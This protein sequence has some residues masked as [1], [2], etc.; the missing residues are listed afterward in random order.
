[1][2]KLYSKPHIFKRENKWWCTVSLFVFSGTT[3][4]EAY[5]TCMNYRDSWLRAGEK[6]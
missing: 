6:E 4:I 5:L 3:P 2:S 1:M